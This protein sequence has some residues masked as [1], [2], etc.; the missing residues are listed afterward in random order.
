MTDFYVIQ[1]LNDQGPG[2]KNLKEKN[3]H[4]KLNIL[5]YSRDTTPGQC[6]PA[7]AGVTTQYDLQAGTANSAVRLVAIFIVAIQRLCEVLL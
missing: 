6:L 7:A 5:A 4:N 2:C 3:A 1:K